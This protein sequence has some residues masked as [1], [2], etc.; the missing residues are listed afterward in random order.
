M[1]IIADKSNTQ[2]QLL[3]KIELFGN[4][5]FSDF[6]SESYLCNMEKLLAQ[7][8]QYKKEIAETVVTNKEQLETFRIK[9]LGTKGLV[10][11]IMGEMKHVAAENKKDAGQLLNEF[12][13]YTEGL[14]EIGRAHV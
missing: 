14:F 10:K 9:Y 12:K 5:C 1:K 6:V 13:L 2:F 4:L 3:N 7:I 8:A 11:T